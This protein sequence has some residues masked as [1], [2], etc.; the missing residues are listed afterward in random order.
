MLLAQRGLRE[1]RGLLV[2]RALQDR[3]VPKDHRALLEQ[4]DPPDLKAR[5]DKS[6]PLV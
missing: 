6:A 3:L 1:L 2:S 5:Q 4:Q